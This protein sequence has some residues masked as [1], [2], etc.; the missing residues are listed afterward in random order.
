[1][2]HLKLQL[3]SALTLQLITVNLTPQFLSVLT[4]LK[5]LFFH[6]YSPVQGHCF[7]AFIKDLFRDSRSGVVP[8]WFSQLEK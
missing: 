3:L 5:T 8:N 6:A 4:Q 1:M 7:V 2:F